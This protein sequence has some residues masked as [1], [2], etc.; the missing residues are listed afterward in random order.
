MPWPEHVCS[1]IVLQNKAA[2]PCRNTLFFCVSSNRKKSQSINPN[3][4][5]NHSHYISNQRQVE[6]RKGH[7][8]VL[9]LPNGAQQGW[10]L[11][12]WFDRKADIV[13]GNAMVVAHEG[14]DKVTEQNA[15]AVRDQ[16]TYGVAV[17]DFAYSTTKKR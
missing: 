8:D 17:K 14:H 9:Q 1:G 3:L 4:D 7:R 5:P 6:P 10:T 2:R 15:E 12:Q 13:E 11:V 16:K